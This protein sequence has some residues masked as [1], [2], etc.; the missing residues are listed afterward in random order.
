MPMLPHPW[1]PHGPWPPAW[2]GARCVVV[3]PP[4]MASHLASWRPPFN[5]FFLSVWVRAA[6]SRPESSPSRGPKFPP[7]LDDGLS[8]R[9]PLVCGSC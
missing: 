3:A 8:Q 7:F 2:G 6:S 9:H 5:V 4:T 1:L